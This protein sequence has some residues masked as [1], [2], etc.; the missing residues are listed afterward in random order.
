MTADAFDAFFQAA[1]VADVATVRALLDAGADPAATCPRGLTALQYAAFGA[2][3]APPAA[4]LA[5][6]RLLLE[7][8]SPLEY[9]EPGGRTALYF[10]A[11]FA[12]SPEPVRLLLDT[13]ADPD[14]RDRH[15]HHVV[16]NAMMPE[17]QRLL[18]SLTGVPVPAAEPAPVAVKM[19]PAQWRAA[20][21]RVRGVFEGLWQDGIVALEDA[22][23]TQSDGFADCS[24]AFHA[25]GG[26]AAGLHGFC[27]Y[28]RQD[29]QA[30]KRTS[31]LSLA[32][33][34]APAGAD[35]DMLRVGRRVVERCR[36]A[37]LQVEW[38]GSAGRRPELD[39][40]GVG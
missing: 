11:E 24:E 37:G 36:E 7:A 27:F 25:H 31:R 38:D 26:E 8:G 2:N 9:A 15:G 30:A 14:V 33:W 29:L 32:F 18:S 6:L 17:V 12:P 34:G 22:G 19:R 28:T 10:A 13:G 20:A 3:Q 35:A 4:N 39:L 5:V 23:Y 40:R 21:A 16:A 1:R